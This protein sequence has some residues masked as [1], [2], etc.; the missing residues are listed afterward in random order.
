VEGEVVEFSMID[1]K[2]GDTVSQWIKKKTYRFGAA[3]V[4]HTNGATSSKPEPPGPQDESDNESDENFVGDDS[5]LSDGS[6]SSQDEDDNEDEEA[7]DEDEDG[8]GEEEGEESGYME[9]NE[10]PSRHP[11]LRADAVMPRMSRAAIDAVV[12]IVEQDMGMRPN[13]DEADGD[14][15]D[16]LMD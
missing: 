2:E 7:E 11:L 10:D 3:A 6:V 15:E 13:D 5:D 14:D 16:E 9:D 12:G 1:G 4:P 8:E